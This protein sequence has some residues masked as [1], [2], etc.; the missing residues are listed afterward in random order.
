VYETPELTGKEVTEGNAGEAVR[1]PC[2]LVNIARKVKSV[3]GETS[4]VEVLSV[5]AN[6]W[7]S[8]GATNEKVRV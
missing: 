2:P 8:G 3:P 4:S 7:I 6:D 1:L 5:L